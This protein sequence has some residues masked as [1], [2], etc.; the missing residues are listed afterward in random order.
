VTTD[1]IASQSFF[2]KKKNIPTINYYIH[3]IKKRFARHPVGVLAGETFLHPVGARTIIFRTIKFWQTLC[4]CL[5]EKKKTNPDDDLLCEAAA[6]TKQNY[7]VERKTT[8]VK[9]CR[10]MIKS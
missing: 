3:D 7:R 4:W 10:Y 5:P 2:L 6:A 8:K 1:V 9:S